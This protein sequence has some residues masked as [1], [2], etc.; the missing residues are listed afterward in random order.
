[1]TQ[2][3]DQHGLDLFDETASAVRGFPNA[4]LGY[5]KKSVD[6][7]VRDIEQQLSVAKHQLREVQRELTAANLRVDDT[8]FA[9][10]GSHTASM[11]QVAE[12]Q[13]SEI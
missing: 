13:S 6:D 3:P 1:M 10:L 9:K 12:A 8:D 5:D 7:Y 4:M 2:H 11:L